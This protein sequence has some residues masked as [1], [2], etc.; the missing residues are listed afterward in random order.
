V[1]SDPNQA[2]AAA[3]D[4]RAHNGGLYARQCIG[5]A[6]TALQRWEPAAI[7]FEQAAR[8]GETMRD[9]RRADLWVQ[10]GNA[11]LAAD[12]AAKAR[13][14]FDAALAT[15]ALTPELRGE[16][17]LDRARAG[18]ALQD[19]ATARADLDQGLALVPAD[20]FAWYLSAALALRQN[21]LPRA[22]QD[23]AKA[24]SL[25][26][27][28]ANVLVLAGNIAGVSGE[29]AAAATFYQR[30]VK[31]APDSDAGK[32][33]ATALAGNPPDPAGAKPT[34]PASPAKPTIPYDIRP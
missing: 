10:S 28:D 14:A 21:A 7:A 3:E 9:P 29:S 18:V 30:A 25:A 4:W 11:W 17:L 23:I 31:A 13:T 20:P 5:L 15:D 1:K 33:A 34:P 6:Y 24:V 8:E 26:P 12:Q 2:L 27:D 16:V 32:S 19:L 22:Q